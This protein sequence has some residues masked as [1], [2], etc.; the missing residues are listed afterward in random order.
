MW[1]STNLKDLYIKPTIS[2]SY[3]VGT[4][5]RLFKDRLWGDF[6]FYNRD[7]K[8]QIINVN[9]TPASGYRS[10]KMNAGLIRNRGIEFSLGGQIIQTKDWTWEL[11]ANLSHNRN[12]LEE[13]I[14]GQDT[15]QIYWRS[16]SS[17]IY[18]YAEVGKPI[19]VIRGS[20]WKKD[21]EGRI[22][23]QERSDPN[24]QYGSYAP[25]VESTAQE[26]LGNIQPDLTG[27]FST[28]LR[29][30]DFHLGMSFDFQIGGVIASATNM[31]GES[32]GLLASTTGTNDKGNPIRA[33]VKDGGGVRIDGVVENQD[34]SYTPVT[35]YVDAS[36]YFQSRKGTI[37]EDYVYKASYLKMRELS[38]GYD[39]P[40]SFL[41]KTNCGIKKAS[42]SFVAQNP[43][44]IYSAAPNLD[45]SE[46]G[47]A[48]YNYVEGGQAASVRTFGFTVNL[49]F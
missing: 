18:S 28:S 49:T 37:W 15:Y 47:A 21:P 9:T 27:G 17:R 14:D 30:K 34:G 48:S 20:T 39:I 23:L 35:A 31:F 19:G 32:S 11:N 25:L 38:I 10:R 4:E 42:V 44:L 36:Y 6:N 41:Q 13:L 46:M 45:P 12:T 24:H 8:D 22:I 2:T 7:S 33:Q 1:N 43:W 40:R 3:E 5:F 26:E 29:Y 16:W